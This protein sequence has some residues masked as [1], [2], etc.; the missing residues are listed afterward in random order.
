MKKVLFLTVMAA[1]MFILA[2]CGQDVNFTVYNHSG[3]VPSGNQYIGITVEADGTDSLSFFPTQNALSD[4]EITDGNSRVIKVKESKTVSVNAW[5]QVFV[6][7]TEGELTTESFEIGPQTAVVYGGFPSAPD[8]Y[9]AVFMN[10][11][12]IY[13]K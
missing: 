4:S 8:W 7:G 3:I 11:I 1:A 12:T 5:G 2:G 6:T 10:E 13:K 9:A